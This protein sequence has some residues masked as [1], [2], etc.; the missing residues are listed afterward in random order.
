MSISTETKYFDLVTRGVAYVNNARIVPVE[1][2]ED[3]L[4]VNLSFLEGNANDVNYVRMSARVRVQESADLLGKYIDQINSDQDKVIACVQVGGLRLGTYTS[5]AEA[6]KGQIVPSLATNLLSIDTLKIN[7]D[8]V[9]KAEK[10]DGEAS[11]TA[12]QAPVVS[13]VVTPVSTK[14]QSAEDDSAEAPVVESA[15]LPREVKLD[16]NDPE[17]EA[18]KSELKASGYRWNSGAQSWV[19]PEAA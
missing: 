18:K 11:N 8:V 4:C 10:S 17:F 9:F 2:G 19:L 15:E 3:Y 13:D 6:T 16:K 7:G 5:K 14:Q 1:K 12:E